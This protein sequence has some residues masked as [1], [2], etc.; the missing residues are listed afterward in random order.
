MRIIGRTIANYDY[1][2][3]KICGAEQQLFVGQTGGIGHA[4]Q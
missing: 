4:S 3:L 1:T 2:D